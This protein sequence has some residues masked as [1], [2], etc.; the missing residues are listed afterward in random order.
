[1]GH[2]RQFNDDINVPEKPRPKGRGGKGTGF[3]NRPVK[4]PVFPDCQPLRGPSDTH[5]AVWLPSPML[6]RSFILRAV[7]GFAADRF[8]VTRTV[9]AS[10][11]FSS[12]GT[13]CLPTGRRKHPRVSL[14]LRCNVVRFLELKLVNL[15]LVFTSPTL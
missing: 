8:V 1:M 3:Y 2:S 12:P 14:L 6:Q 5:L 7:A 15:G 10:A 11:A 13:A 4:T 9:S